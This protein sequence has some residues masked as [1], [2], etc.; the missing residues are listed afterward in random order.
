MNA[1]WTKYL[2]EILREWLGGRHD[3]QKTVNITLTLAPFIDTL[4]PMNEIISSNEIKYINRRISHKI[5]EIVDQFPVTVLTGARQVGKSTL[6]KHE[7][8]DFTY[9]TLDDFSV[10]EQI[11]LDPQSLWS[12]TDRI[13]IDEAQKLP[14]MFDAIKLAVDS[15]GQR[16]KFILSGSANMLL[17]KHVTESLAGRALYVELFPMTYG[18]VQGLSPGNFVNLW[19]ADRV[20]S[21]QAVGGVDPLPLLLRGFMPSLINTSQQSEVLNWLEGYVRTYLE[22]D[23]R[24]LSQVESLIDFRRVM[25]V[26]ALRTGNILNQAEI[27]KDSR[28][29]HPTTHRYIRLLEVSGIIG[30]IPAYSVNRTKRL[31][32]SPKIFYVD[33]AIAIFLSGYFDN[34]SLAGCRELG[35]FFETMV[36]HHLRS[37]CEGMTPRA[38]LNYWRTTNGHEIDFVIEHGRRLLAFE[39]K[40]TS[41]P[42]A[43]DIKHLLEFMAEYPET[44]QGVLVHNGDR[45]F[46]LHSKVIAVPWW[47][48]DV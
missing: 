5:K 19:N 21:D 1:W 30:R 34:A 45:V 27:A 18:E 17:M 6:L 9:H 25:Q 46:H 2:P 31:V 38:S 12:A 3:L 36:G 23:L 39:V 47:W 16:K 40:L 7:F 8:P 22:R 35:G 13:I 26:L 33:P 24:E 29:S 11:K 20:E 43:H 48:L 41:R 28:V 14:E 15:S 44:V 42:T 37:L 10:R 32:K 4:P